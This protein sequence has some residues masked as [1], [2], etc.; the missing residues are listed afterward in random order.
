MSLYQ[1]KGRKY[2]SGATIWGMPP[3]DLP[4]ASPH[5]TGNCLAK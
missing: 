1:Q 2:C 4:A 5:T 3:P